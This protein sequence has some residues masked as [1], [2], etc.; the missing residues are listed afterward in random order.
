M[1]IDDP[2]VLAPPA[3]DEAAFSAL[4]ERHRRELHVHCYRML[5]SLDDAEDAVQETLLRAWRGRATFEA[6]RP[7]ASLR[8]W[9]YRIA[10]NVCLDALKRLPRRVLASSLGPPHDPTLPALAPVDLPWLEPYPDTLLDGVAAAEDGPE[11]VVVSRETIEIAFL[12]AIQLLPPRQRATVI[13][14]DV[15]GWSARETA[16]LL[17]TSVAAVNS[18]LQR[19]RATSYD[20]FALGV[21]PIEQGHIAEITAFGP[22]LFAAF[23]L[24]PT[25]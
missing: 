19:A 25:W 11:A 16:E 4:A 20:A 23:G 22:E 24:P 18:A 17:D 13:L 6:G 12:A 3:S 7:G 21:L 8:A 15:L 1:P 2:T 5:G 14:F 10:T 9:L